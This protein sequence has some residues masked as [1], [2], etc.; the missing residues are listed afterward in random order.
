MKCSECNSRLPLKAVLRGNAVKKISCC[1]C[2][3]EHL[4]LRSR[5]SKQ[6]VLISYLFV[7]MCAYSVHFYTADK[8]EKAIALILGIV[9]GVLI[10]T[11]L[12][13]VKD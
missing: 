12:E 6:N 4:T 10:L 7:M 11:C 8:F 3:Y 5:S 1:S 9:L 13:Y 2:G